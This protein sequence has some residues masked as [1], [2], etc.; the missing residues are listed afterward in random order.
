MSEYIPIHQ[1]PHVTEAYAA[2]HKAGRDPKTGHGMAAY[3]YGRPEE[4]D[5]DK[6]KIDEKNSAWL[7]GWFAGAREYMVENPDIRIV[8]IDEAKPLKGKPE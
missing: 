4:D 1:R 8:V 7:V 6:E 2:G 5:P 3:F